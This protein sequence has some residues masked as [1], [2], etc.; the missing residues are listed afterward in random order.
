MSPNYFYMLLL[1][2]CPSSL[3]IYRYIAYFSRCLTKSIL[4]A[5]PCN[6]IMANLFLDQAPRK[7]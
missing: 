7:K 4:Y 6:K 5:S 2:S 1:D 3:D